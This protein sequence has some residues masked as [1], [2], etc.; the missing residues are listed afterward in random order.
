MGADEQLAGYSRHRRVFDTKGWSGLIDEM[1]LEVDR[2]SSRNLG[3]DDRV[4]SDHGREP[5]Y[6]FLDETVID[7]LNGT[8]VWHKCDLRLE[9]SEGE[10]LLLRKVAEELGLR[11][12]SHHLK[13][14][15]QFGSRIAKM[16]GS[17]VKGNDICRKIK[18]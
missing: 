14:A 1:A 11:Q 4:T 2:L 10:K 12:T 17:G 7:F 8:P 3:R 15:I 6:P 13:R 5:R 18:D 9:R 16:E